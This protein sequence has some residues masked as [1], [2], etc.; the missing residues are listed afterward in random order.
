[1]KVLKDACSRY[2]IPKMLNLDNGAPY[3]NHQLDLLAARSGFALH[4]CA[5]FHGN[6]IMWS[7]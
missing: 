1:M 3:K 5:V 6:Q 4:H 7:L 2:G